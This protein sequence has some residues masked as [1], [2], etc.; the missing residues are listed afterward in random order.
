MAEQNRR[1]SP[2]AYGGNNPINRIDPDGMLDDWYLNLYTAKIE[3]IEGSDN[4]FDEG[5]IHL[6]GDEASVEQIEQSLSDKNYEFRRDPSVEGGYRVNTE[7]QYKGWVMAQ[8]AP[9]YALLG[10]GSASAGIAREASVSRNILPELGKEAVKGGTKAAENVIK[11][12]TEH[13]MHQVVT[14]EFKTSDILKIVKG[15]NAVEAG[16]RFGHK[17][18]IH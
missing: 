16:G 15:G 14:R 2:Y 17:H 6:T 10:G 13:G 11:G 18:V 9:V 7:K 12:F 4:H 3:Y 5:Y 1:W 8:M